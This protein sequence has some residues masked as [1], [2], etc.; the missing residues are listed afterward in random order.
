MRYI[1]PSVPSTAVDRRPSFTSPAYFDLSVVIISRRRVLYSLLGSL[2][3]SPIILLVFPHPAGSQEDPVGSSLC[4][5]LC[6]FVCI[7]LMLLTGAWVWVIL[8]NT[9]NLPIAVRL[10]KMTPALAAL[11]PVSPK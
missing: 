9:G 10:G 7:D 8:S 3:L 11:L 6:I 5:C 4:V 2:S 1:P